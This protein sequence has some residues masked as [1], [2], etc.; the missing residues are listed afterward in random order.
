MNLDFRYLALSSYESE[1]RRKEVASFPNRP[2]A[3]SLAVFVQAPTSICVG[4][5]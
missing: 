3:D 1:L 5:L 2:D 4:R